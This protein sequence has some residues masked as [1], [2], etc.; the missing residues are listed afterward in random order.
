VR[1]GWGTRLAASPSATARL[2]FSLIGLFAVLGIVQRNVPY[3]PLS[4]VMDLD[5][6]WVPPALFSALLLV[7]AG[8]GYLTMVRAQLA[9]RA[10]A[11]LAALFGFM[12]LDEWFGIHENLEK[13][14]GIP[15][16]KLYSPLIVAAGIGW[17]LVLWSWRGR[18][19]D[20]SRLLIGGAAL[21]FGAQ[22]LEFL[23]WTGP[24]RDV[25]IAH[26]AWYMVP[27]ELGEMAGSTLFLLSAL[28]VLSS[29]R[30][31]VEA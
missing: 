1:G 3:F 30:D 28:V 6:E 13:A 11:W 14:T 21:W 25:K 27:E 15:W 7:G 10:G 12:S 2:C 9:P 24:D 4:H 22:V 18:F 23:Q 26:Y 20:A 17:C 19:Q 5:F 16:L 31:R 8:L 29:V